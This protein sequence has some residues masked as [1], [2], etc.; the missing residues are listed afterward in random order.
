MK[1]DYSCHSADSFSL[2][3]VHLVLRRYA[4]ILGGL[5]NSRPFELASA[6]GL[7]QRKTDV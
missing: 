6:A 3:I 2:A 1:L 4:K 7:V 5:L